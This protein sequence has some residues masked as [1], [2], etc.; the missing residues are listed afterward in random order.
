[1][2]GKKKNT[3][4]KPPGKNTRAKDDHSRLKRAYF[5]FDKGLKYWAND[6]HQQALS[7]FLRAT[8]ERPPEPDDI[9]QALIDLGRE[10]G[11]SKVILKGYRELDRAG[12]LTTED[13]PQYINTM[14]DEE[15]FTQAFEVLQAFR[16]DT[17]Q[18]GLSKKTLTKKRNE[19]KRIEAYCRQRIEYDTITQRTRNETRA[20]QRELPNTPL[21]QE[22]PSTAPPPQPGEEPVDD[23]A[24]PE[25]HNE[26]C[27]IPVTLNIDRR[28]FTSALEGGT[29]DAPELLEVTIEAHRINLRNSFE[30]LLCLPLLRNI[31]SFWY[32]EETARKVVKTFRGRAMLADEV[33]LGKTV[34]ACMVLREYIQRGMVKSVL[35]LTPTPLVSQWQE[36]LRSKFDLDFVSTDDQGSKIGQRFWQHPFIL[37]SINK[38][39]SKTNFERVTAREYDMVIVDEAHHL[40]N[41]STLNWKLVNSLK[42]RFLLF[43]TA[44]PVENNLMELYNLITLLKPGLLSTAQA[45]KQ[46]FVSQGDTVSPDKRKRLR[47]LLD[48]VMIRNTR[49]LAAL[50]IPPRFA[51]T[52]RIYKPFFG[53]EMAIRC[54]RCN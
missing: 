3:R 33:G 7:C 2:A 6:K 44:T 4:K 47:G 36:E 13:Y 28:S 14:L 29:T 10:M 17:Q 1:M 34:E 50:N 45:F 39:K 15:H 38:A 42:K 22:S 5:F 26:P 31:Q 49:A 21:P 19:I 40:K 35:I 32:Q 9:L 25:V 37:S 30:N 11:K 20:L 53:P 41:K 46:E 48:Q 18:S 43:L 54:P 51:Q 16:D 23:C 8:Q 52:V 12:L 24:G 27:A